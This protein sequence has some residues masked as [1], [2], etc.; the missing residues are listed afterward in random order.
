MS[1]H[2]AQGI[3]L[4]GVLLACLLTTPMT[5]SAQAAA[6]VATNV[7]PQSTLAHEYHGQIL[8]N[9]LPVPG[10]II[11][12]TQGAQKLTAV[13][14]DQG[15]YAFADLSDG[16]WKIHVEMLCF[17]PIDDQVTIG[18][19]QPTGKWE[20]KM[21]PLPAIT[22]LANAVTV[23]TKPAP[24]AVAAATTSKPNRPAGE[25]SKP[26]E[27]APQQQQANDGLLINGS[28]NNA[29]T[30]QYTLAPAFGNQHKGGHG[31]YN[32][33]LELV[34]DNSALDARPYSLSGLSQ[35]KAAY[36]QIELGI[37]LGGPIYIPHLLPNGPNFFVH[38]QLTRNRTDSTASG[39]M[40]T[41]DERNGILPTGTVAVSPQALAL[42]QYYPLPN[43]AGS[44]LYNY[45]VPIVND[46]HQDALQTRL[47]KTIGRK[48]Q[49]YGR[50]AFQSGRSNGANIFGF[51][52][53]TYTLGLNAGLN[54][55]HRFTSHFFANL[56][57]NFSRIR[58][59]T[60]PNFENRTDVE[61]QAGIT[62]Y[63]Q[64]PAQWGPPSLQFSSGISGLT[65]A[66]SAFNRNRTGMVS[67][68]VSWFHRK[69]NVTF[70]GDFRRQEF[71]YFSQQNPRGSFVFTGAASGVSDLADFLTGKADTVSIAYG[72]AD[73]YL[74]QSVY[75][76][77]A[78]D[79]WR[80]TPQLT[81]LAG[82]RW[83]YGAPI[84]EL[85]NRLVNIDVASNF[86]TEQPVLASSPQGVV[87]GQQYPTSLLRPDKLG[88]QPRVGISW[89]PIPGSTLVVRAGYGVYDD[90]SVYQATALSMAQQAPLSNSLSASYSA[91]CPLTL[92]TGLQR[93][94]CTTTT[95]DNFGVDP[96]FR[97]GF[98]Q[99]W[100]VSA[101]RDLPFALQMVATYMGVKGNH[102]VQEFLP[103]TYAIGATNPCPLCSVGYA[104]RTS[105]GSSTREA[106][107]LQLRRRLRSGFTASALYTYS[108]SIDD[109]AQLGG[110]G[111]LAAGAT[112]PTATTATVAQNWLNLDAERGLSTFDQRN[113]LNATIQ[114]T[115][116]VGIGGGSLMT[117]WRG[118]VLKDWTA[119]G[120]FVV[121]SGLPETPV[122]LAA[123]PGTGFTGDLR[124]DRTTQGLKLYALSS[125]PHLNAGAYAAPEAGVFGDAGRDS[126]E[127]PSQFTFNASLQRTFRLPRKFYL[128]VRLDGTNVL[129]HVTFT[130]WN[131]TLNP[132]Q[133]S[134]TTPATCS[135]T[136]PAL[137]T[138][139]PLF[140]LPSSAN[141]MRSIQL[142]GRLRF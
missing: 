47:D 66:Q 124:P 55:Q 13:S 24:T 38:Y 67:P 71:N 10:A 56:G 15:A 80:L 119:L 73:K 91:N 12:A 59:D 22:A 114:Y 57:Y 86:S 83:D 133:C 138:T 61:G 101:Q 78:N 141:A 131:T 99:T 7:Q 31:L 116:G 17:A 142:T 134:L 88:F 72:N 53:T 127:G 109:D 28:S 107:S 60:T 42:L 122:Y 43:V 44:S 81:I 111:P 117:G 94:A 110:Q 70:G 103:N 41:A 93:Q 89:R 105:N 129:N 36:N 8:Y 23:E 97:V 68:N 77:Y 123:T 40:P 52:D 90:T 16:A 11:T 87:S 19:N 25:Q 135:G 106:G 54:W 102:G 26:E 137:A 58:I 3:G 18:A 139:S 120:T 4:V 33:G 98:A 136:T 69:H 6:P 32:G 92:A 108:K 50:F 128:D 62:G 112:T 37:T 29:A 21:L 130:S 104:Y 39:L 82:L 1:K 45:Q 113:L 2:R 100:Q 74:R 115:S 84:T 63:D 48:D 76:L 46:T 34:L 95:P 9:D 49:L 30:S 118:R 132:A 79:D 140:G 126:I 125:G 5:M 65:D 75:D 27:P 96:N 64:D 14:D 35:P 20:L 121:G 51:V 85:K